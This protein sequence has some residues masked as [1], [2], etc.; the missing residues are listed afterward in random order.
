MT[1]DTSMFALADFLNMP[2]KS[3]GQQ[4]DINVTA[5]ATVTI[6]QFPME[7]DLKV[8]G[9]YHNQTA[10]GKS[11]EIGLMVRST[12]NMNLFLVSDGEFVDLFLLDAGKLGYQPED[13][14]PVFPK[15]CKRA[16]AIH[17]FLDGIVA[18]YR[19]R[20]TAPE[21]KKIEIEKKGH[22]KEVA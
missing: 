18:A 13:S 10:N 8:V 14:D 17:L 21:W 1:F 2:L 4:N 5:E 7:Y 19:T 22:G 11:H 20:V 15:N 9:A 3:K 12:G 6:P 16:I